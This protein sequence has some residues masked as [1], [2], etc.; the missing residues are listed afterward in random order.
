MDGYFQDTRLFVKH[1]DFILDL[2]DNVGP[3][4]KMGTRVI[5][6]FFQTKCP[7]HLNESDL[8]L[9]LRLDDFYQSENSDGV[10]MVIPVD[11]YCR[12]LDSLDYDRLYIICDRIR[13]KWEERY[14]AKFDD[15]EP[16]HLIGGDLERD[17]AIMRTAPRLIHSNST[18]CWI[19]SFLTPTVKPKLERHIVQLTT[20][21][22]NCMGIINQVTDTLHRVDPMTHAEINAL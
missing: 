2:L 8:V 10:S 18:L 3:N 9:S 6:S 15:Y 1:R 4:E 13:H 14:L 19:N 11:F 21:N 20:N 17:C 22:E 16:I 5:R 7:L 12:L